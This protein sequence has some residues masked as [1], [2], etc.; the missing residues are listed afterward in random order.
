MIME[1]PSAPLALGTEPVGKLL[2]QYA[3]PAVIGMIAMSVYNITDSIFIGHGVGPLALSG[4]TI[5]FPI[6]N[7]GAAFGA[8]VGVGAAALL[9][10]RLGQKDYESAGFILGNVV[11]LNLITGIGL[12]IPVLIWLEPILKFFGASPAVLP[13]AYDFMPYSS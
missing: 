1:N 3:I 12:S 9:S 5:S 2:V 6:M 11:T 10:I 4:L 7:L 13:Y 8:L